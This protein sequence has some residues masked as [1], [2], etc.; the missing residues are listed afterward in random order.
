MRSDDLAVAT[1]LA[2]F[3]SGLCMGWWAHGFARAVCDTLR[4]LREWLWAWIAEHRRAP[5]AAAVAAVPRA[6]ERG[7]GHQREP[8]V[9]S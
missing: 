4:A 2:L 6:P 5:T 9:P 7:V 1:A 3:L 8:S